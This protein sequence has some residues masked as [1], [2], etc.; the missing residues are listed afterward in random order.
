MFLMDFSLL[1][2]QK[3]TFKFTNTKKFCESKF[4]SKKTS[5]FYPCWT[6]RV[7]QG[8]K[9]RYTFISIHFK[10]SSARQISFNIQSVFCF[11]VIKSNSSSVGLNDCLAQRRT[12]IHV[13]WRRVVDGISENILE[14]IIGMLVQLKSVLLIDLEVS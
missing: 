14:S 1:L 8:N 2:L 7:S 5:F 12:D 13:G 3:A 4:S 6:N 10:C 11:F 9:E